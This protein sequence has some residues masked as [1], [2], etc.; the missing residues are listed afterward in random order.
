MW[1]KN[2]LRQPDYKIAE[3]TNFER[4]ALHIHSIS[5]RYRRPRQASEPDRVQQW[6]LETSKS[7]LCAQKK[8]EHHVSHTSFET[9]CKQ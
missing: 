2:Q 6:V 5:V 1:L 8:N 4:S 7:L 9:E 3:L